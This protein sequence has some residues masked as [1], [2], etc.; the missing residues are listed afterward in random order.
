MIRRIASI[1]DGR[2]TIANSTRFLRL[3]LTNKEDAEPEASA[4]ETERRWR[5]ASS[6]RRGGGGA[7]GR[8]LLPSSRR[9]PSTLFKTASGG[10]YAFQ[11]HASDQKEALANAAVIAPAGQGKTTFF[12][13]LIGGA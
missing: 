5:H 1:S 6:L 11:L 8:T 4:K 7:R 10:G 12:K 9:G 2:A 3:R 13:H